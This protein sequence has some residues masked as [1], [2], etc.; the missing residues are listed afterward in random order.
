MQEKPEKYSIFFN[1][2]ISGEQTN[3]I[4]RVDIFLTDEGRR[5]IVAGSLLLSDKYKKYPLINGNFKIMRYSELTK[6]FDND[7]TNFYI[8]EI[9]R[10]DNIIDFPLF[11]IFLDVKKIESDIEDILDKSTKRYVCLS[12]KYIFQFNTMNFLDELKNYLK[13]NDID[14]REKISA[15]YDSGV[16]IEL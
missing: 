4:K 15:L 8:I 11:P 12:D 14:W 3:R 5:G 1:E 10:K 16:K 9:L 7:Y 2:L 6:F 13:L